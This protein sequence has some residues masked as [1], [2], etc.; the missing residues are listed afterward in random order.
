MKSICLLKTS[1]HF[2]TCGFGTIHD[3]L[4]KRC[5]GGGVH[6]FILFGAA[7]VLMVP[8]SMKRD[9]FRL[10]INCVT[11]FGTLSVWQRG[12]RRSK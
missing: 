6:E 5:D 12:M 9:C 3:I 11:F 7:F 2:E 1:I 4:F 8:S 10:E